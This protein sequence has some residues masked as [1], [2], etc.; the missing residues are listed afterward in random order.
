MKRVAILGIGPSGLAA[1]MAVFNAG[2]RPTL[3]AKRLEPSHLFG[4]QYLHAPIPGYESV[5]TANVNYIAIGSPEQYREKVYGKGWRGKVSPEDFSGRHQA[6]DIRET[7]SRMYADLQLHWAAD[8]IPASIDADWAQIQKP[9]L[10]GF[11]AVISTIPAPALCNAGH[12]FRSHNVFAAGDRK[13]DSE[14]PFPPNNTVV[15]DGTDEHLWYRFARVFGYSTM[16]WA[17]APH[18]GLAQV[19]KPLSTNCDC[20]PDTIRAG[21]YGRWAKGILVHNVYH[22]VSQVMRV[23]DNNYREVPAGLPIQVCQWCGRWGEEIRDEGFICGRGHI[24]NKLHRQ[25]K[26]VRVVRHDPP[27]LRGVPD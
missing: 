18:R 12:M 19:Q 26:A 22:Q 21:R 4:C 7:Y 17:R 2:G 13:A 8:F 16:E 5:A 15:C 24:W 25:P 3:L 10:D 9:A 23:L 27:N 14:A 6:W 11:D 1:A 20:F